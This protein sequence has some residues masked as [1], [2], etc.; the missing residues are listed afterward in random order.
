MTLWRER[1]REFN[2]V[3][4]RIRVA[5]KSRATDP[6]PY[7]STTDHIDGADREVFEH[8]L[9]PI[10]RTRFRRAWA[11]YEAECKRT[12]QDSFGDTFYQNPNAIAVWL[13]RLIGFTKL[14]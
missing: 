11:E 6:R 5:L 9:G 1:R 4:A 13:N 3:A 14:R 10:K 12:K 7:F 8:L 2:E